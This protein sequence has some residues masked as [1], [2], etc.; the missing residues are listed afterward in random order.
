MKN[1][2]IKPIITLNDNVF[3]QYKQK[4]VSD[5]LRILYDPK[6]YQKLISIKN[7]GLL[8]SLLIDL[9]HKDRLD[10]L[11]SISESILTN[12]SDKAMYDFLTEENYH[13]FDSNR[14]LLIPDITHSKLSNKQLEDIIIN[15]DNSYNCI[16]AFKEYMRRPNEI[17][18]SF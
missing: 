12:E 11:G 5:K 1:T 16:S 9:P 6:I 13:D 8:F 4:S 2:K 15:T 17:N 18:L 3:Y 10:F 14:L 7:M